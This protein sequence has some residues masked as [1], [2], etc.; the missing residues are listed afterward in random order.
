M[1]T[2]GR[3]PEA[4]RENAEAGRESPAARRS[5]QRAALASLRRERWEARFAAGD[6]ALAGLL[7]APAFLFQA[8]LPLKFALFLALGLAARLS[9]KRVS[10]LAAFLVS[11]SI[12]LTNLLVPFGKVLVRLGPLAVT[13]GALLDGIDKALTFEGLMFLSKATVRPGLRLPGRF[14]SV[15]AAAFVY[16]DRIVGYSG[17]VRAASFLDDADELMLA[18]WDAGEPGS[19][20]PSPRQP[21]ARQGLLLL[22]AVIISWLA[23]SLGLFARFP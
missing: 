23:L 16:Y 1:A 22:A 15:V 14:G 20:A 11:A 8:L 19:P 4:G 5:R 2:E 12:V 13:E 18:V 10:F 17:R 7:I 9:G 3:R 6:L 21:A